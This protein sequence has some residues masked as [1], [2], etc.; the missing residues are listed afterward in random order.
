[1]CHLFDQLRFQ[2]L[3][4]IEHIMNIVILYN[5]NGNSVE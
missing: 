1:M 3:F 4:M 2:F 5:E